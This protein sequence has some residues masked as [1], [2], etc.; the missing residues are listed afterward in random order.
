MPRTLRRSTSN[1]Y[2]D[3]RYLKESERELDLKERKSIRQKSIELITGVVMRDSSQIIMENSFPSE[4]SLLTSI[5][6]SYEKTAEKILGSIIRSKTL[7]SAVIFFCPEGKEDD[8]KVNLGEVVCGVIESYFGSSIRDEDS[9]TKFRDWA[10]VQP[11]YYQKNS[12]ISLVTKFRNRE[13]NEEMDET[14]K[15]RELSRSKNRERAKMVYINTGDPYKDFLE[16]YPDEEERP[17][18]TE[19]S[20]INPRLY[21]LLCKSDQIKMILRKKRTR[22]QP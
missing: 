17:G 9:Y 1:L 6:S 11:E 5:N 22:K 15:K 14:K 21:K 16:T 20:R 18:R 7:D 12:S 4:H 19:L 10:I 3:L 8:S 13:Y 2:E